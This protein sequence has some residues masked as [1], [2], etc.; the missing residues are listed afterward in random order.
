MQTRWQRL[1]LIHFILLLLGQQ[2]SPVDFGGATSEGASV[3]SCV[4]RT[5]DIDKKVVS[6]KCTGDGCPSNLNEAVDALINGAQTSSVAHFKSNKDSQRVEFEMVLDMGACTEVSSITLKGSS[7]GHWCEK[8]LISPN[9]APPGWCHNDNLFNFGFSGDGENYIDIGA[10]D[11][12]FASDISCANLGNGCRTEVKQKQVRFLRFRVSSYCH[13]CIND[14]Y[15]D[16]MQI[17]TVK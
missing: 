12:K 3:K 15:I 10:P 17:Q 14:D 1:I 6:A 2:C 13:G 4:P 8:E 11:S 9:A 16:E 5:L 7:T